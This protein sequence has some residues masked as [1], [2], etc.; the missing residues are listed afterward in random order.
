MK[1]KLTIKPNN[2]YYGLS[3]ELYEE[4]EEIIFKVMFVTDVNTYVTSPDVKLKSLP[5]DNSTYVYSF[6]MPSHDVEI[7]VEHRGNMAMD[8]HATKPPMMGMMGM[9]NL[10]AMQ[11]RQ[12]STP[13]LDNTNSKFCS[14][15]GAKIPK[16]A[17]FCPECGVRC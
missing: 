6:I 15:C 3:K 14:E 2:K 12:S 10:A 4:G 9:M 5:N 11:P 16:D 17:K 8:P 13:I 7:N 1:Y